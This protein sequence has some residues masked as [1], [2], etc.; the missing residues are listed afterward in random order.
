[1]NKLR[2]KAMAE[3]YD[4]KFSNSKGNKKETWKKINK[5][6][7]GNSEIG[8]NEVQLEGF[9]PG[10]KSGIANKLGIFFSLILVLQDRIV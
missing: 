1:M 6:T 10:D 8:R 7:G 2:R 3:Y 5:M 4:R 9:V